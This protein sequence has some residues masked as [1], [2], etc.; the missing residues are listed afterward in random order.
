LEEFHQKMKILDPGG[1]LL[2][3]QNIDNM[4]YGQVKISDEVVAVIAGLA[5][6]EVPGVAGMSGGLAGGIAE[7][8][9]RK[10]LSKGVKVE[11]GDKETAV[12]LFIVVEYGAKIPDIAWKI[13]ENVKK[14]IE[15]MTGLQVVEVNVHVQGVHM[16]KENKEE[17]NA[18]VK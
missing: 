8:L 1:G 16:E 9:G 15:S 10:N 5:A 13:Q 2:D 7:M 4:E 14:A 3:N 17:D 12:D 11:V 6:T 18:R